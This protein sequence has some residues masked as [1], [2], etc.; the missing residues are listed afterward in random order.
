[1]QG[2]NYVWHI[3]GFDKIKPFGFAIHACIDGYNNII[4]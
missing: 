1:M 4:L 2:P 3:D